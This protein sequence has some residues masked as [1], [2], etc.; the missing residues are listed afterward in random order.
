MILIGR[1]L[2]FKRDQ[3]RSGKK[4]SSEHVQLSGCRAGEEPGVSHST[5]ER[6]TD[7]RA[8]RKR[9]SKHTAGSVSSAEGT[10]PNTA[11][12]GA[13]ETERQLRRRCR[14]SKAKQAERT[15][16]SGAD[17]ASKANA[18]RCST[19]RRG[20]NGAGEARKSGACKVSEAGKAKRQS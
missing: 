19:K 7:A 9:S 8:E 11:G 1:G 10:R 3:R 15:R 13:P 5:Q 20:A 17:E 18:T 6:L 2:D 4:D 16:R 14:R 12:G